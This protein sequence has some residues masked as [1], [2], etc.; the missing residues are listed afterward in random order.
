VCRQSMR[1]LAGSSGRMDSFCIT[2]R[3]N[4]FFLVQSSPDNLNVLFPIW[5]KQRQNDLLTM[6]FAQVHTSFRAQTLPRCDLRSGHINSRRL[7][8]RTVVINSIFKKSYLT[9]FYVMI[10]I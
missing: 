5:L 9:K 6:A 7:H 1:E 3:P 10:T 4:A 8:P 2:I